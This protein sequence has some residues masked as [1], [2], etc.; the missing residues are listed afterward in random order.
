MVSLLA[1]IGAFAWSLYEPS[2]L[3]LA[4]ACLLAGMGFLPAL[5]LDRMR[6]Q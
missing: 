6:G 5:L 4:A 1:T 3:R 2:G